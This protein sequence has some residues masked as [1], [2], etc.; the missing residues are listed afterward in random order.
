MSGYIAWSY[1]LLGQ[2]PLRC[3]RDCKDR[4]LGELRQL[5]LLFRSAEAEI[6][7]RESQRLIGLLEGLPRDGKII[8]ELAA[9]TDCLR[10]LSGKQKDDILRTHASG[11]FK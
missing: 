1:A 7:D 10:A 3:D 11:Y 2:H 5:Q 8:E 4:R 9:H 6:G